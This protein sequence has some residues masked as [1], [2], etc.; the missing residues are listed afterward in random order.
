ML[1]AIPVRR[2]APGTHTNPLMWD[3]RREGVQRI[4]KIVICD[5]YY[6]ATAEAR[7]TTRV[8]RRISGSPTDIGNE[9]ECLLYR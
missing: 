6:N 9:M 8:R 7:Q 2:V 4:V 5:Q 1:I 3:V